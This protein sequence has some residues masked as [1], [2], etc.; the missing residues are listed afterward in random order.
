MKCEIC[1]RHCDLSEGQRGACRARINEDGKIVAANFGEISALALDPIEKKPLRRFLPGTMILSVGSYGC[2]L[3]CP[4][5]QN[6]RIAMSDGDGLTLM[7]ATPAEIAAKAE[8]LISE[9]NV[10]LAY[11]YNEPLVGYEFVRDCATEIKK[12]NLR[13]V[14]V[15]NGYIAD[16]IAQE[17]YPRMDAINIDLKAFKHSFYEK[18]GGDLEVVKN[19]IR[20]AAEVT[21][22]EVTTL[23]I[24]GKNDSVAE[25]EALSSW[26]AGINP[27][28][29]LHVSRFFPNYKLFDREPTPV[30]TIFNLAEIAGKHLSHVYCGNV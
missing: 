25:M 2:N 3:H 23:I 9:G 22:L 21:H 14:L 11:T 24:P 27:E 26:I 8:E 20:K 5:C 16:D 1:P 18:I 6:H 12:Y 28:I 4:F 19:N 29:P 13:N 7:R 30:S 15:T 10:G 17:I